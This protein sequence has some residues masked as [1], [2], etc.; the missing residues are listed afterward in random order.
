MCAETLDTTHGL[1]LPAA[2]SGITCPTAATVAA[3][4]SAFR[5]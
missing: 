2:A 3:M 4:S 5:V 1:G